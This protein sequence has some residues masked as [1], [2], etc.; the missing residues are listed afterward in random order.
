MADA[1]SDQHVRLQIRAHVRVQIRAE[2]AV[3]EDIGL[4]D[5]FHLVQTVVARLAHEHLGDGGDGGLALHRAVGAD[6]RDLGVAEPEDPDPAVVAVHIAGDRAADD[7]KAVL[8]LTQRQAAERGE[9]RDEV[10]RAVVGR[11]QRIV[12]RHA[13]AQQIDY[14]VLFL[15]Q[16]KP[17]ERLHAARPL[18]MILNSVPKFVGFVNRSLL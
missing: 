12:Q 2:L 6:V 4:D 7:L 9:I 18:S 3:V 10:S 17:S 11:A 15:V 16:K 14:D 1:E 5:R 13:V 8:V